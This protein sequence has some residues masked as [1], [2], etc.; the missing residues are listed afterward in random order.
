[1]HRIRTLVIEDNPADV[2]LIREALEREIT[3]FDL[4]VL[5]NGEAALAFVDRFTSESVQRPDVILLD[6]NLPRC[7]GKEVLRKL[8]Q[9]PGGKKAPVIVITSSNSPQDRADCFRLGA[10]C[11]FR[12]GSD[13][14]EFMKIAQV[15]KDLLRPALNVAEC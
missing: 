11:Y 12:K 2:Y 13:L 4:D 10:S 9:T 7:D 8:G 6:L 3:D 15:V 14:G 1:M 5:D